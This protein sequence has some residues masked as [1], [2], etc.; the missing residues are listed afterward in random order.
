M[1]RLPP[2]TNMMGPEKSAAYSQGPLLMPNG[3]YP[4]P[5]ALL[6]ATWDDLCGHNSIPG[7]P[8]LW[9]EIAGRRERSKYFFSL[10]SLPALRGF[11]WGPGCLATAPVGGCSP[12]ALELSTTLSVAS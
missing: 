3:H 12:A 6:S 4:C 1:A 10:P 7:L 9:Q 2:E 8:C 11:H 5:C